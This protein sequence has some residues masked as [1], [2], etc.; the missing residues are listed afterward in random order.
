MKITSILPLFCFYVHASAVGPPTGQYII[1]PRAFDDQGYV[2]R[3]ITE[4]RS[5][6]PKQVLLLNGV[7]EPASINKYHWSL[8]L[9]RAFISLMHIV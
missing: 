5:L 3:S 4:D 9:Y 1:I 2:G 6:N 8:R 7:P